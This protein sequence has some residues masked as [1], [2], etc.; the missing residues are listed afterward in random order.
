MNKQQR[1]HVGDAELAVVLD[2]HETQ[3]GFGDF[4]FR[5]QRAGNR[6]A[7]TDSYAGKNLPG[8]GRQIDVCG[9]LIAARAGGTRHIDVDFFYFAHAGDGQQRDRKKGRDGADGE[10]GMNV[11]AQET[12]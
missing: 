11:D 3:A 1:I 7:H 2:D 9:D 10:L 4:G 6:R 12:K 5:Q 8:D